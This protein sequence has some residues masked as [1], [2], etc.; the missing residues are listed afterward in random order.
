MSPSA[1][2]LSRSLEK[3]RAVAGQ[4]VPVINVH[5][6]EHTAKDVEGYRHLG[7]E[8]ILVELPTEPRDETLRRLDQLQTE[9]AQLA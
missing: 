6:G 9:F 5:M 1:D 3:L 8:H 7:V 2:V 4:D